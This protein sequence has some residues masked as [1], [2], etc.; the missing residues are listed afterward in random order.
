[1]I[2]LGILLRTLRKLLGKPLESTGALPTR[3]YLHEILRALDQ[4]NIGQAVQLLRISKRALVDRSR[5]ELVRQQVL[6]RCRVLIESHGKRIHSI[7]SRI[8]TFKGPVRWPWQWLKKEPPKKA[9]GYENV[10]ALEERAKALLEGYEK[11]LEDL[12]MEKTPRQDG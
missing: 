8:K 12:V 1:M 9:A 5:W 6:F 2:G 4:D 10:L 11:E 3:Y 7:E